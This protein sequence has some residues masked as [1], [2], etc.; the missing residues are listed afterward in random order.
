MIDIENIVV[1]QLSRKVSAAFP[2]ATVYSERVEAPA[3]LPCIVCVEDANTTYI[4]AQDNAN[5]EH[6]AD[7]VYTIEV[8]VANREGRKSE[9]KAIL[10]VCDEA[11]LGM[12]F[13][14]TMMT[15]VPS[16]DRTV[17]RIIA[18]YRAVVGEPKTIDGNTVYQM[19]RS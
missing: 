5:T 8:Y 14:R 7:V 6:A 12:R 17:Y 4:R 2:D 3:S 9:A 18:R 19:Y 11:M 1:D 16:Y 13:N 10:A 15:P